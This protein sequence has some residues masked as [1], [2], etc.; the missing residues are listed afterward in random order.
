MLRP[1]SVKCQQR[2]GDDKD[3]PHPS[4][5]PVTDQRAGARLLVPR[6]LFDGEKQTQD[7]MGRKVSTFLANAWLAEIR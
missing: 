3:N 1:F 4:R 5:R 2:T 6:G 7:G